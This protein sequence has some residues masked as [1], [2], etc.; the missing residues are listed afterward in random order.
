VPEIPA[1]GKKGGD[2]I[3]P[4]VGIS[5]DK[6]EELTVGYGEAVQ[7]EGWHFYR[8]LLLCGGIERP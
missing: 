3:S 7:K 6:F 4:P 8:L 1:I 5:F 2:K